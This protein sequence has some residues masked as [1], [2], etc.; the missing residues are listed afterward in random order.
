MAEAVSKGKFKKVGGNYYLNFDW[1]R[2]EV[3]VKR[4]ASTSAMPMWCAVPFASRSRTFSHSLG[5]ERTFGP[6]PLA[7]SGTFPLATVTL[8]L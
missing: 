2:T 8:K 3:G 1:N 7:R 5:E 6:H 4:L